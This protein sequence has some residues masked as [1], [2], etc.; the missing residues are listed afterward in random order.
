MSSVTVTAERR[1]GEELFRDFDIA[2]YANKNFGMYNGEEERVL[3][4]C[5]NHLAGVMI[6][7]FGEDVTF[8]NLTEDSFEL[9]IK[10]AIS[11]MFLSWIAN[12]G[13]AVTV[14]SPDTV[15]DRLVSHL[16]K[17]LALYE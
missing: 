13:D 7:R 11:P 12:F 8:F 17:V 9:Y 2:V 5:R 15:R 16:K 10:A 4:R 1:T 6:D 3:L 14:V